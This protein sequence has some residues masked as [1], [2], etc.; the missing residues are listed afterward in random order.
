G[1]DDGEA[2]RGDPCRA[3]SPRARLPIVPRAVPAREALR[4]RS[5]RGGVRASARGWG[6]LLPARRLDPEALPRSP[7]RPR[8]GEGR[9]RESRAGERAGPGL[10]P[11]RGERT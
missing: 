1:P 6:P 9:T 10:L 7:A 11:L 2:R 3:S 5:C 8:R 4:A